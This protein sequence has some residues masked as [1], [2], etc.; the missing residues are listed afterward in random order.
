MGNRRRQVSVEVDVDLDTLS[1]DDDDIITL[2]EDAGLV[3]YR[4]TPGIQRDDID[5][6]CDQ[7]SN[8]LWSPADWDQLQNAMANAV[9]I[10]Q[11]R[12]A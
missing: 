6:L 5:T 10:P 4:V 9:V 3:C 12:V 7:I 11:R 1:L 2:A 8:R